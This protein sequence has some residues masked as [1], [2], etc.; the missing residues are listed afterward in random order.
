EEDDPEAVIRMRVKVAENCYDFVD[1]CTDIIQNLA[2]STYRGGINPN[3][4]TDDPSV[5]DF[6]ECGFPSPGA[7][8]FLLDDLSACD[9]IREVQL[10]GDNVLDRK[11]TRLNSSHVKISYAVFCLKKKNKTQSP[12]IRKRTTRGRARR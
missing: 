1:A 2:Y 3:Q 10:C 12:C 5:Y 7:T 11:S 8:N 9:F 6:S 4:I